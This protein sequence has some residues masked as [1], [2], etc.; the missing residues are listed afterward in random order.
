MKSRSIAG[1][2]AGATALA[3]AVTEAAA[4][5]AASVTADAMDVTDAGSSRGGD[6][7]GGGAE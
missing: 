6:L 5:A 7:G 2:A 3:G 4:G 1:T